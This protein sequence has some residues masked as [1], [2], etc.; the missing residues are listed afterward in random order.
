MN[1]KILGDNNKTDFLSQIFINREMNPYDMM[2]FLNTSDNDIQ[3]YHNLDNIEAAADL[4]MKHINQGSRILLPVD[5]DVDGFTSAAIFY[6]FTKEIF[7]QIE[8]DYIFHDGKQH[9]LTNDLDFIAEKYKL[10][11]LIDSSSNDYE[12]HKL[13][14]EKGIDI[15]VIDHHE[16]E[17][18]SENAIVVNNQLSKNYTNK[19]F[20]GAGV[21]WQFIRC[22]NDRYNLF[23]N[24]DRFLDIAATGNIADVMSLK[25]IET[26]HIAMKG[27]KNLQNPMLKHFAKVQEFSMGGK[28]TPMGIAFY[29]APSMNA[30]SRV[31]TQEEKKMLFESLLEDKGSEL[32]ESE[33]RGHK[34]ELVPLYEEA[35][36][37]AMN[38]RTRQNKI[39]D[40]GMAYIERKIEKEGLDKNK[41]L[42]VEVPSDLVPP[43]IIGLV[44][45]KI[46]PKYQRPT[47]IVR[48]I[49]DGILA[50]SGRNFNNSPVF[51]FRGELEESNFVIYVRGC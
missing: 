18:Y 35:I 46:A 2:H 23:V 25:S 19:S 9:G 12:Q 40:E 22:V 1:Y 32:V 28:V 7:P 38:V 17:K 34:G 15:I 6:N 21:V 42:I 47:L 13:L 45:N 8:I 20:S 48:D 49:G 10:I 31:G 50:G 33:K 3:D 43:E 30:I 27:C 29:M 41:L 39:V 37:I 16:A 24:V 26:K 11:V 14:K 36:R 44:A 4:Y 5:C 51:D